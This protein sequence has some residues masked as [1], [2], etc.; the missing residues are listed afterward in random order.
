MQIPWRGIVVTMMWTLCISW[1]LT[2]SLPNMRTWWTGA[3][4]CSEVPECVEKVPNAYPQIYHAFVAVGLGVVLLREGTLLLVSVADQLVAKSPSDLSH[5]QEFKDFLSQYLLCMILCSLT[6]FET[7]LSFTSLPLVHV[8]GGPGPIVPVYTARYIEWLIDVPLLMILTCCGALGRPWAQALGPLISTNGYIIMSWAA[9]FI[10]DA[11]VR[12]M[13]IATTFV[14]YAWASKRMIDWVQDFLKE[15]KDVPCRKTRVASVIL[16]IAVFGVYGVIYLAGAGGF[17]NFATEH[18]AYTFA[19]FSCKVT[20]S[21]LFASIRAYQNQQ[22]LVRLVGRLR[23]VSV[24]FV[25]LLRGSFDHVVPC[26]VTVEGV[27]HLP[28]GGS[29]LQGLE[30]FLG[31]KVETSGSFNDLMG[32]EDRQ[33]FTNYVKNAVRQNEEAFQQ[34][35]SGALTS[36]HVPPVAH[37][38]HISLGDTDVLVHLSLVPHGAEGGAI[39]KGDRKAFLA[40]QLTSQ[41]AWSMDLCQVQDK[42]HEVPYS[43]GTPSTDDVSTDGQGHKDSL[44]GTKDTEDDFSATI[45]FGEGARKCTGG[46]NISNRRRKRDAKLLVKMLHRR[47]RKKS[48]KAKAYND[49]TAIA[50]ETDHSEKTSVHQK[51]SFVCGGSDVRSQS[52]RLS[53]AN[54]VMLACRQLLGP[55]HELPPA[56][57][58]SRRMED[59]MQCSAEMV[60]LKACSEIARHSQK[61]EMDE[62]KQRFDAHQLSVMLQKS[63]ACGELPEQLWRSEVLGNLN[64][65]HPGPR[66]KHA[67]LPT[68]EE[69]WHKAWMRTYEDESE[70]ESGSSEGNAANATAQFSG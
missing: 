15:S 70:S 48:A 54:S 3:V 65:S 37:A 55:L 16:L 29:D 69:L 12:S 4:H 56:Q 42:K 18:L 33:R 5:R 26:A 64:E 36:P 43:S 61:Q 8:T 51:V 21:I 19:G 34:L 41:E 17:I 53:A 1:C 40:L 50:N 44:T 10:E 20:L 25:S 9:L 39:N 22:V 30:L 67:E 57:Y 68:E 59:H 35:D 31:K 47:L 2:V 58:I 52:S 60:K 28:E 24:A 38:L 45:S 7:Y 32:K 14:A 62:W 11:C 13:L 6:A 63:S 49:D 66:P 27:C 46:K 23:G